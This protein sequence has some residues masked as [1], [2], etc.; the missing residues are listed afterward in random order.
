[1]KSY[2]L[3]EKGFTLIE[4]LV[5]LTILAIVIVAFVPMFTQAAMHNKINGN[6][7]KTNEA[8]HVVAAEYE[9][10]SDLNV[11]VSQLA[12]CSSAE[13]SK[14]PPFKKTIGGK[15][16]TVYVDVCRYETG[17]VENLVQAVFTTT[18]EERPETKGIARK[19]LTVGET[20]V[21][22]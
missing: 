7:L 10:I 15:K 8:A 12:S 22:N 9:K 2:K 19:F 14:L 11:S 5:S 6:T 4:I 13:K 17:Q 20:N 21:Q 1:M 18:N 16:Y 3:N